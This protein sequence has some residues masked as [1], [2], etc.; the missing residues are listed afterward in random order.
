MLRL[1]GPAL[2]AHTWHKNMLLYEWLWL[3][4][5]D[6]QMAVSMAEAPNDLA[7]RYLSLEITPRMKICSFMEYYNMLSKELSKE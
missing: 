7:S 1:F 6:C 2:Q 4:L 5:L 3:N